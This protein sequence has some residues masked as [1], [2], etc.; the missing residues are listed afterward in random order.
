MKTIL[1]PMANGNEDIELITIIDILIRAKNSGANLDII[2]ASITD[3][4]DITL[5]T[6][7]KIMANKTLDKVN[8][9]NIDAIALAGGFLGMTNL[10]NDKRIKNI[11][12]K[13][14]SQNKLIAAICASPIVLANAGVLTGDFTCYPGCEKDI[15][16]NRID[17]AVVVNK[18]IITSAGPITST[19]FAL[20]IIKE[21]GFIEQYEGLLEGL[22][23]N[24]F[25]IKF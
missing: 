24:K 11:I 14:N 25:G 3:N 10:K 1:I 21:L 20:T 22:L 19:Y 8:T 18:N 23:I 12:Q 15:N 2:L 7:L 9:E 13:L 16:A 4:L 5:D 6:G 17:K